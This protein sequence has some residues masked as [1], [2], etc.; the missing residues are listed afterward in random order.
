MLRQHIVVSHSGANIGM[1][2]LGP[3]DG[4]VSTLINFV[5]MVQLKCYTYVSYNIH[6]G[7][8]YAGKKS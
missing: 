8:D 3:G 2:K 4:D 7:E 6:G 5:D 1:T